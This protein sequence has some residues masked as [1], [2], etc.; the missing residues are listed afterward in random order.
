[1]IL[2]A[3]YLAGIALSCLMAWCLGANDAANPTD[4]AVGAGV[5]SV[6]RA[7]VLFAVFSALGGILIG[8]YVMKTFDRGLVDRKTGFETGILTKETLVLGSLVAALAAAI[9]IIFSTAL[10]MPISTTHSA[11]GGVLGFGLASV[12]T[13]IVWDKLKLVVLSIILSPLLSLAVAAGLFYFTRFLFAKASK[14]T[15]LGFVGGVVFSILFSTSASAAAVFVKGMSQIISISLA[16]SGF[17]SVIICLY[18][19]S[20]K[21]N[22][23][24]RN[25]VLAFLLI[26]SLSFSAFSFGANDLANATGVFVTPTEIMIGKP[27]RTTMLFLSVLGALFVAFGGLTWGRKVLITTA[28]RVTRLDPLTGFAAEFANATTVFL[29]TTVPAWL[30]GFGLPISTTHSSVG[31]IVGVGLASRGLRGIHAG[32][33]AKILIFWALTIPCAALISAVMF[34]LMSLIL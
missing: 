2:W 22:E 21:K 3:V 12:P 25:G 4:C 6:E 26:L 20:R 10:G 17:G 9:W 16:I 30:T 33:T 28:Y 18:L 11:I 32:T 34:K 13:L 23:E 19:L 29:F 27:T 5:I 7:L 15:V 24:W 14:K 31:S 8:S 1:M